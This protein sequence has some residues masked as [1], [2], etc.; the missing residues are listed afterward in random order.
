MNY[1][2]PT[3]S[4][5]DIARFWS[6]IDKI[7]K[8]EKCWLWTTGLGSNGY[9]QFYTNKVPGIPFKAH[10]ISF[11]ITNEDPG[12]LNV[13]H[14]C[15]TP[16][17]VNPDH[18]WAGTQQEGMKDRD[19]KERTFRGETHANHVLTEKQ[20]K[21]ILASDKSYASL[22]RKYDVDPQTIANLKQGRAWKHLGGKR[23]TGLSPNNTSG[24]KGVSFSRR[25][26]RYDAKFQL[27]KKFYWLGYFD[28]IEEAAQA[29]SKKKLE[30]S[31]KTG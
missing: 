13:N 11:A 6:K 26:G 15:D 27:N 30:L 28:T 2:I 29:L 10:R 4:K 19:E 22:S 24:V 12:E 17:C 25:V 5:S 20:A 18:L 31:C 21:K 1:P 23:H 9:G 7:D 14:T 3:L 8:D 16:A